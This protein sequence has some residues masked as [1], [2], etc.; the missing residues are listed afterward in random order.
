MEVRSFNKIQFSGAPLLE[1][2]S[3]GGVEGTTWIILG[4]VV[5]SSSLIIFIALAKKLKKPPRNLDAEKIII[6]KSAKKSNVELA[7]MTKIEKKSKS[8]VADLK[9]QIVK[10][11]SETQ[12]QDDIAL[13]LKSVENSLDHTNTEFE[14]G[15]NHLL[16]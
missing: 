15:P 2:T 8:D 3:D 5:A 4:T 13:K 16:L 10:S 7:A 6:T 12:N 11:E 9:E 1:K 14:K